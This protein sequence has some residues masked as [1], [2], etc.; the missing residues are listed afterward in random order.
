MGHTGERTQ[1]RGGTHLR[2]LEWKHAGKASYFGRSDMLHCILAPGQSNHPPVK[3]SRRLFGG[4]EMVPM[5]ECDL[6]LQTRQVKV[7]GSYVFAMK[8]EAGKE[9]S[10]F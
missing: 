4:T 9:V 2:E 1:A 3:E 5:R 8:V 7:N 10:K 6:I